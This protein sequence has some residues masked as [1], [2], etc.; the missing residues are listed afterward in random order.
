M[1]GERVSLRW[2]PLRPVHVCL[3][4]SLS[5]FW[6]SVN[7]FVTSVPQVSPPL[8]AWPRGVGRGGV[9]PPPCE[10]ANSY[11]CDYCNGVTFRYLTWL[12][13][14]A[15]HD[16]VVKAQTVTSVTTVMG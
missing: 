13:G 7:R 6:Q 14:V 10:S 15:F 16:P 12:K 5:C 3:K 1:L 8:G 11:K 2:L 4:V 9:L